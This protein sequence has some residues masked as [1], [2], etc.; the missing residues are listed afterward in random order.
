MYVLSAMKYDD[1]SMKMVR[2][3]NELF[4]CECAA[5]NVS[6]T[7]EKDTHFSIEISFFSSVNLRRWTL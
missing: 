3:K 6:A 7:N 5:F 2:K 4:S 1:I